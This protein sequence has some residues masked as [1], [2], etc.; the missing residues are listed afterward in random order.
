MKRFTKAEVLDRIREIGLIPIIRVD[1]SDLARRAIAAIQK[2]GISIIEVTM[3][4][5][6]AVRIIEELTASASEDTLIG[7]GTVLTAEKARECIEAGAQFIVSPSV[8]PETI[9]YCNDEAVVVLPGAMT[10]TEVV[11]A[12]TI[13]ADIVKIFPAGE[14]GG[15]GFIKALKGPLPHIKMIPTGGVTLATAKAFLEAGSEA[16]GV[17]NDLV[18]VAALRQGRDAYVTE[19]ARQYVEIVRQVRGGPAPIPLAKG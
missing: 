8:N 2:G 17:G 10:P 3:T 4:V 1:S 9:A 7:A 19:R 15:P 11:T 5:P 16:L 13:G 14:V 12:W 6:G 18:D